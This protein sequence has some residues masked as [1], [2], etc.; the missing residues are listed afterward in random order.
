MKFN[1]DYSPDNFLVPITPTHNSEQKPEAA[2][3]KQQINL[4]KYQ[5]HH[6][7]VLLNMHSWQLGHMRLPP[8]DKEPR[9]QR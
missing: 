2:E 9:A 8:L 7:V 5:D 4:F 1:T 3:V 6:I